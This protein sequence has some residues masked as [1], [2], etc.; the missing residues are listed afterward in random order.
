MPS[1]KEREARA[2][3]LLARCYL[4]LIHDVSYIVIYYFHLPCLYYMPRA[5][6]LLRI[7][8]SPY[9]VAPYAMPPRYLCWRLHYAASAATDAI[10]HLIYVYLFLC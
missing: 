1:C 5:L 7:I 8:F 2:T 6:D 9:F 4:P 10:Y 3:C